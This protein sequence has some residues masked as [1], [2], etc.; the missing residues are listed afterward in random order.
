MCTGHPPF[1]AESAVA[2]LRRVSDDEPRPVRGLNAEVPA[3][4]AEIIAKLHAKDPA[5]RFQTAAEVSEL[6]GRCLAHL[7]QP[8]TVPLPHDLPR[9]LQ[10][11]LRRRVHFARWA[12]A[13][14]VVL[15]AISVVLMVWRSGQKIDGDESPG[16]NSEEQFQIGE[17]KNVGTDEIE[18]RIHVLGERTQALQADLDPRSI[19]HREDPIS[20]EI[21]NTL[22]K[23]RSLEQEIH[24]GAMGAPHLLDFQSRERR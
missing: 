4:L 17:R 9:A 2:V 14:F 6:L 7:Q 12:M 11:R 13:S 5:Q 1:R 23:A 24:S 22:N 16:L 20:T 19:S 15:S 3:W 18:Q 10:P 21:Q 8:L